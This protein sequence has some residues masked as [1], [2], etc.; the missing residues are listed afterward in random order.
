LSKVGSI[1]LVSSSYGTT[2][3]SLISHSI[4]YGIPPGGVLIV[5]MIAESKLRN[6]ITKITKKITAVL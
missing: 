3:S 2:P 1:G 4:P 6:K 5:K